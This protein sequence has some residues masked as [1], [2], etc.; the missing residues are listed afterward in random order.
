MTHT[1]FLVEDDPRLRAELTALLERYGYRCHA[2]TDFTQLDRQILSSGAGLVLLDLGLPQFDGY[3]V[4]RGVRQRSDVPIVV[5]T[6][7]DSQRDELVAMNLGCDDFITKPY[8]PDILLARIA[9]IL[10]RAYPAGP[11]STMCHQGLSLD[12][13]RSV[14]SFQGQE[15]ELTKNECR[16]LQCL[17]KRPG[18]IVSRDELMQALWQSEEFVDDNTL[19][20]NVNRLR[21]RLS[22]LGA[23]W[24]LSTRRGLGYQL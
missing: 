11:S 10:S 18:T 7:R 22:E 20:V 14:V 8:D 3:H 1:I 15:T 6:S 24:M 23:D 19:T 16:I 9:R 12:L 21:R 2:A 17:M 5:V 13:G 4:C